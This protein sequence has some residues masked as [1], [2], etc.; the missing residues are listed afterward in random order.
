MEDKKQQL[1]TWKEIASH[2]DVSVRTAQNWERR[3]GLPVRRL[4]G[5]QKGSVLADPEDLR[6]WLQ[7][8]APTGDPPAPSP[9]PHSERKSHLGARALSLGALSIVLPL[10]LYWALEGWTQSPVSLEANA[11][12]TALAARSKDEGLLWTFTVPQGRIIRAAERSFVG[13]GLWDLDR[14]GNNEAIVA[15]IHRNGGKGLVTCFDSTGRVLWTYEWVRAFE[16]EGRLFKADYSSLLLGVPETPSGSFVAI[17]SYHNP[18]FP[19]ATVLL[20]PMTG[21]VE[22]EFNHPGRV[23]DFEYCDLD[24]EGGNEL[25]IG[26][27]NNPGKGPGHP[28]FAALKVPFTAQVAQTDFFGF[29]GSGTLLYALLPRPVLSNLE[30]EIFYVT[31]I[32]CG[33]NTVS[34]YASGTAME[35]PAWIWEFDLDFSLVSVGPSDAYSTNWHKYQYAG[36]K[37]EEADMSDVRFFESVPNGN[38]VSPPLGR[39]QSAKKTGSSE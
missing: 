13:Y 15:S 23:H 20:D 5:Q 19:S 6:Q 30:N 38:R 17:H 3:H 36:G 7:S 31:K 2:L 25:L 24:G 34:V 11:S 18:W 10:A 12:R 32:V 27:I 9:P 14:D 28:F 16:W 8:A 4:R 29:N 35:G 39:S 22:G 37:L 26:G 1:T 21:K 33:S